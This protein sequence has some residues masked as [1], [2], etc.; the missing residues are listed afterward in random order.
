MGHGM[1]KKKGPGRPSKLT[2]ARKNRFLKAIKAGSTREAACGYAGISVPTLQRWMDKGRKQADGP[3][4]EFRVLVESAEAEVELRCNQTIMASAEEDP[5]W[6]AW[7]LERRR[8]RSYAPTQKQEITGAEGGPIKLAYRIGGGDVVGDWV[9]PGE[10][11]D[12]AEG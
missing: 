3:Y 1:K 6:A 5:K 2:P 11:E 7:W 4:Q 10:D 12:E 8:R 9:E